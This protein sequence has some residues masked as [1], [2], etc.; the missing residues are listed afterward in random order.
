MPDATHD[1]VA[2]YRPGDGSLN[3]AAIDGEMNQIKLAVVPLYDESGDKTGWN[4]GWGLVGGLLFWPALF[5]LDLSDAEMEE[6]RAYQGRWDNLVRMREQRGCLGSVPAMLDADGRIVRTAIPAASG[7]AA[8]APAVPGR[9]TDNVL[10][11]MSV[12]A[13]L[14]Q[15]GY[16]SGPHDG[17]MG[18]K[19]R[20]AL[21]RFQ[22]GMDIPVTG[23][24]DPQ[25]LRH[26]DLTD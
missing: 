17:H 10:W 13:A 1:P 9:P 21:M 11:V 8:T 18:R 14:A 16:W 20:N 3:C 6:V 24:L 15:R 7:P 2:S 26:L 12:Q 5:A 19:T 23:K 25:T 22:S 4:V